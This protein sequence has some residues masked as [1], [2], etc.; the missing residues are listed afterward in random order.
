M[1]RKLLWTTA[2]AA[3]ACLAVAAAPA[4]TDGSQ[5]LNLS[6]TAQPPPTP[7]VSFATPPGTQV[8]FGTLPFSKTSAPSSRF[9]AVQPRFT[10]CSTDSENLLIAGTD[11]QSAT[12]TWT[13]NPLIGNTCPTIGAY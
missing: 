5:T 9:G 6:V 1:P 4:F 10:N 13:L 3:V 11:A 12:H 8:D 2:L 7:C